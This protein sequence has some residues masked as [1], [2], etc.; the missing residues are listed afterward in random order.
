MRLRSESWRAQGADTLCIMTN[1]TSFAALAAPPPAGLYLARC[2][3][4][5][6]RMPRVI[7]GR[8][9][10]WR[11]VSAQL[12]TAGHVLR[13]PNPAAACLAAW[14]T[15]QALQQSES[16]PC[17]WLAPCDVQPVKAAG[18]TF[19]ASLLERLIEEQAKGDPARALALRDEIHH[20]L[21]NELSKLRPGSEAAQQLAAALKARGLWSAYLEVGIG[22][23][24]EIFTK[25]PPMAAVGHGAQI[26]IH[27][28]TWNNPE[29]EVVLA[30]DCGGQIVGAALGNDV[31]LRD[32]E[33]RSALLLGRAKDNNASTAIGPWIRLFDED[34]SLD[35][36][37]SAEIELEVTGPASTLHPNGFHT[38]CVNTMSAISRDPSELAR[39]LFDGHDY[40]DGA[41]LFC[42]TMAVPTA[43]RIAAGEGFTHIDGDV[44]SIRSPELGELRNTVTAST[45]APPWRYGIV[46]LMR[47]VQRIAQ[48]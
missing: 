9:G 47:D 7:V 6:H 29:P 32:V 35:H 23:D 1:L 37:R 2:F 17:A 13:A 45:Q 14:H 19:A 44:V 38:R 41:M 18:V 24:A 21:G 42:G 12:P 4:A 36:V 34:F 40:P 48:N 26:G 30:I 27:R 16:A 8:Q 28:S 31:N 20:L 25:C 15:S 39:Q 10:Q 43:D 46:D 33:G 11:D 5:L 22:P 3:S